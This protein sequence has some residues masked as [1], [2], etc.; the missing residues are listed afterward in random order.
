[1]DMKANFRGLRGTLI[2]DEELDEHANWLAGFSYRDDAILQ[3]K[4]GARP[5]PNGYEDMVTVDVFGPEF[6][7]LNESFPNEKYTWYLWF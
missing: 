1:M 5:P 3:P 2:P 7:W 6:V 4:I